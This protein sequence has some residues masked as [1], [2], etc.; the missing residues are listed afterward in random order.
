MADKVNL[1][2]VSLPM[3]AGFISQFPT[4]GLPQIALCGRSNVGKSS[5]VNRLMGQNKLA[6][7]S[8]SP[9]KT[10][11]VNFYL[12]DNRLYL[13]DLPGYGFAK[14]SKQDILKWSSLTEG[15]FTDN[16]GIA[17]LNAAIVLIDSRIGPT[18]DDE[19][20]I[21]YLDGQSIDTLIVAT[22]TDKLNATEK[23]NLVPV[24]HENPLIPADKDVIP[25]SAQTGEGRDAVLAYIGA[26]TGLPF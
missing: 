10:V 22:K 5:L 1:H 13:V 18:R 15:Y 6:R 11:T 17:A 12:V 21:R 14:R 24:L 19:D 20:M 3:A 23:K 8:G 7:V 4:D 26:K 9:G 2:R 25:F 16:R